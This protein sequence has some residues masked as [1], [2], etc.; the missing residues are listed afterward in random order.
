VASYKHLMFRGHR[1]PTTSPNYKPHG[2]KWLSLLVFLC[3]EPSAHSVMPSEL[4]QNTG[5]QL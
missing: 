1:V 3:P 5:E 2:A 4:G